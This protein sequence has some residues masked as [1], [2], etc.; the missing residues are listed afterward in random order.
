M[1]LVL[2]GLGLSLLALML[3]VLVHLGAT[4]SGVD[5][6]YYLASADELR[7]T[8]RLPIQ[9]PQYL[10]Q[11]RTES[12]APG[13][14]I[15]LALLPRRLLQRTF[16]LISPLVDALHVV[17]LYAILYR[18]TNS[19]VTAAIGGLIYALV[20]QL[21][22]ETRSLSP[23]ALG[24][25]LLS[26][27]MFLALRF[28]VPP[29][30]AVTL[31]L[32]AE[33]WI[34]ALATVI[35]MA[36]LVLTQSPTGAVA[37]VVATTALSAVHRDP[38][39]AAFAG[40]G[41]VAAYVLTGGF[42]ARVLRNHLDAVRFWRRNLH[43]RGGE[44][45]LDSP[46]YGRG[47]EPEVNGRERRPTRWQST[48]WQLVRLVGENPFVIP[49]LLTPPP[50]AEWWGGRMYWWAIAVHAWALATTVIPPLRVLGPGYMYLKAAVFPA[51]VTVALSV[52]PRTL[53]FP[54][55]LFV[56]AAGAM[57]VVVIV[58]FLFYTRSKRTERTSS[59]PPALARVTSR[60][61][62]SP[63]DGVLVLPFM[64]ADYVCY[65]AGKRTLWGGHSGDLSRFE[66]IFPVVRRPFDDLIREYDLHYVLL[67]LSYVTPARIRLE[68]L[69]RELHRD[70]QFAL[71]EIRT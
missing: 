13:F 43:S 9:L 61:R 39:Y 20:P 38:R 27:S 34:V 4:P 18:L 42:Y 32:G 44:P 11:D 1:E 68:P 5:T 29:E 30:D 2:V 71:Y 67:D 54:Y 41:F 63:K 31:R 17:L 70:G 53:G 8:R 35:A 6:W 3:R 22:A 26:V 14:I 16:W 65:N 52:G 25:L 51:A 48:K 19:I 50:A 49:M 12:Y 55:G 7:R 10:L 56:I 24:V 58:F 59:A 15:F 40:L 37:L 69:L 47:R 33:P 23:R 66:A 46:I 57:S 64:Y 45:I 62:S 36:T 60:L 28:T 21:V